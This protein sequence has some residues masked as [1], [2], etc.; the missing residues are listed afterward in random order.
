MIK[1]EMS[2]KDLNKVKKEI[3][4]E[5]QK[6]RKKDFDKDVKKILDKELKSFQKENES[7][8]EDI[9]INVIQKLVNMLYREK[10]TWQ[11]KVKK[12]K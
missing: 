8:I 2:R 10:N 6:Q 7:E 3:K 1:E 4:K 9:A 12:H 5:I 11:S